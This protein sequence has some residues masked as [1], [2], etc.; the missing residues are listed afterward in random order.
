MKEHEEWHSRWANGRIGF[1]QP[2]VNPELIARWP[3][4]VP[5]AACTVLVPLCGKS[6]D[7]LW[8]HARGHRVIGVELSERACRAFFEEN[9]LQY[10]TRELGEHLI[11]EGEDQR[12]VLWCGDFFT[13][14]GEDLG[15]VDAFYDRAAIVALPSTGRDQY[16]HQL[17]AIVSDSATGLM[18]T[19]DYPQAERQGPPYSVSAADVLAQVGGYFHCALVGC[20]DLTADNRWSL[21]RVQ[22]PILRLSRP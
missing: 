21:S 9:A 2:V 20:I 16:A 13:I 18:L 1:H 10:S 4:L 15:R 22:A 19:F 17:D 7:M 8:L 12:L 3:E 11:F 14:K 6:L 5:D